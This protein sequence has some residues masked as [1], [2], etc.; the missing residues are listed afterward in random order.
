M[1]RL[2]AAALVAAALAQVAPEKPI[3][4]LAARP[5]DAPAAA[6]NRG[7]AAEPALASAEAA[8]RAGKVALGEGLEAGND[9]KRR[10][11]GFERARRAFEAALAFG[12]AAPKEARDEAQAF[13]A[14]IVKELPANEAASKAV[15]FEVLVLG[16]EIERKT[17][18]FDSRKYEDLLK[19]LD[20]AGKAGDANE[21]A[22][23][24]QACTKETI[25][26]TEWGSKDEALARKALAD[27][28]RDVQRHS[29]GRIDIDF[30]IGKHGARVPDAGG[31][32]LRMRRWTLNPLH[33]WE[34]EFGRGLAAAI[35]QRE[36]RP[37]FVFVLP[38]VERRGERLPAPSFEEELRYPL[39]ALGG[40]LVGVMHVSVGEDEDKSSRGADGSAAIRPATLAEKFLASL[41]ALVRDR[42]P[43]ALAAVSAGGSPSDAVL[44]EIPGSAADGL[45][46]DR[47]RRADYTAERARFLESA[48]GE[49]V[50]DT[51]LRAIESRNRAFARRVVPE[52]VDPALAALFDADLSTT[53]KLRPGE[54]LQ[55]ALKRSVEIKGLARAAPPRAPAA[56]RR[57]TITIDDG[58]TLW[59]LEAFAGDRAIERYDLDAPLRVSSI[60]LFSDGGEPREVAEVVLAGR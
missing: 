47:R 8:V 7:D 33:P 11:D 1:P 60:R 17:A 14:E 10:I 16:L 13:L 4:P 34:D 39:P 43:D 50:T 28:R 2:I 32:G 29:R 54:P 42:A 6:K 52:T 37:D 23:A 45:A 5:A 21:V 48:Y 40:G 44:P 41:Y 30:T 22:K 31:E 46:P 57:L 24:R 19:K 53:V 56:G 15:K 3:R 35:L 26:R 18:E 38:K 55:V 51:M 58:A 36:P 9:G 27:A 59:T 25:F 20:K 49:R 12:A